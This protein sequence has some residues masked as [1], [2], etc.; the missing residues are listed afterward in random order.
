MLG[1]LGAISL[2]NLT[3]RKKV[4][5]LEKELIRLYDIVAAMECNFSDISTYIRWILLNVGTMPEILCY[6]IKVSM[7]LSNVRFSA[8]F[9]CL[10]EST[11][12][13]VIFS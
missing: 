7:L 4:R 10:E 3:K 13:E 11:H 1:H 5:N 2:K 9:R 6:L 12:R 8:S